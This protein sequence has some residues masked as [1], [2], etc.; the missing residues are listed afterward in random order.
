MT[1][2]IAVPARMTNAEYHAHPAIS[3]SHLDAVAKSPLHY[4]DRYLNPDREPEPENPAFVIGSAVH[5]AVL[6]PH[7][8]QS[9]YL[10]APEINKRTKDGKAEWE[11]FQAANAGKTVLSAEDFALCQRIAAAVHRHEAAGPLFKG[12]TP[13]FSVIG[14]DPETGAAIKCRPDFLRDD[15]LVID[16]KTTSDAS[17]DGFGKSAANFRYHVQAAWY[18]DTLEAVFDERPEGFIF[19]A[20]EKAAPYAV[21]VYRIEAPAI[22]VGRRLA[23]RDLQTLIDCQT[24]NYWPDYGQSVQSLKF[25][26]WAM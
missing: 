17:P 4:W 14:T 6:E 24:A 23:R 2:T 22:E 1:T 13:E 21:G 16:L 11:A 25:P 19:V 9:D 20:V 5:A 8:F 10:V 3:K 7:V 26:R 18:M 12:G 15:G